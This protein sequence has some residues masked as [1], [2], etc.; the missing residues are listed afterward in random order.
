MPL[1]WHPPSGAAVEFT[2]M[3]ETLEPENDPFASSPAD[4]VGTFIRVL[5]SDVTATSGARP[6]PQ[7]VFVQGSTRYQIENVRDLPGTPFIRYRAKVVR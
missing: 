4:A 6:K 7:D 2:G 1:T 5:R 3:V